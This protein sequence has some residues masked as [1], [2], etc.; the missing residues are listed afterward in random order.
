MTPPTSLLAEPVQCPDVVFRSLGDVPRR[1]LHHRVARWRGWS[2]AGLRT[3]SWRHGWRS[4]CRRAPWIARNAMRWKAALSSGS[5]GRSQCG[6]CVMLWKVTRVPCSTVSK[7]SASVDHIGPTRPS[8][9]TARSGWADTSRAR[10]A[11]RSGPAM[12]GRELSG[13]ADHGLLSARSASEVRPA[14][15][16]VVHG[17]RTG[18]GLTLGR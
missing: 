5:M 9:R 14:A 13:E 16:V 3:G 18:L 1:M 11:R 10:P 15:S 7:V 4:R 8:Y 12:V 6:V 17:Q 2:S